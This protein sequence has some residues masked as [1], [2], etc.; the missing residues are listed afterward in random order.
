M[1]LSS[2]FDAPDIA[3]KVIAGMAALLIVWLIAEIY[4][5]CK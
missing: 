4:F 5:H 3:I 2:I 1:D